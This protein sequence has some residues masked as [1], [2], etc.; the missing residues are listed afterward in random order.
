MLRKMTDDA[1][2]QRSGCEIPLNMPTSRFHVL[3]ELGCIRGKTS[4]VFE[5]II[6]TSRKQY[7]MVNP[8]QYRMNR[9]FNPRSNRGFDV[10]IDHGFFN[11]ATFLTGIE[12]LRS[13]A[14]HS[15]R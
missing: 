8:K 10:A 15:R 4:P 13:A 5:A 9:L 12:D 11:E 1:R 6:S 7:P 2:W 3:L 14:I